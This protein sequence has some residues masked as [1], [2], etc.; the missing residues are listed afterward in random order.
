VL[1]EECLD[2]VLMELILLVWVPLKGWLV[3]QLRSVSE[4]IHKLLVFH[5]SV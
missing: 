5:V 4:L 2:A 1:S 3:Q